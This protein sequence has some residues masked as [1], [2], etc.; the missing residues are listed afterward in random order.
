VPAAVVGWAK[1]LP[2]SSSEFTLEN[3]G[4]PIA[5]LTYQ[6]Q[7]SEPGP[8][9]HGSDRN[10]EDCRNYAIN[11]FEGPESVT[12]SLRARE[13]RRLTLTEGRVSASR[14]A[15]VGDLH[16]QIDL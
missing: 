16:G 11:L 8:V 14:S 6:P 9:T 15:I 7:T 10:A 5:V 12:L 3:Q 4:K 2:K 1:P 13:A